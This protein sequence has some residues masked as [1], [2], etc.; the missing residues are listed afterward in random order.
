M[1]P[2]VQLYPPGHPLDPSFRDGLNGPE[3]ARG[4]TIGDD[5]WIGGSAIILGAPHKN[6]RIHNADF[7]Q[8]PTLHAAGKGCPQCAGD[9]HLAWNYNCIVQFCSPHFEATFGVF[10]KD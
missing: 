7:A 3:Y 6:L 2:M 4:I 10:V 1:G 5:V 8:F 9:D